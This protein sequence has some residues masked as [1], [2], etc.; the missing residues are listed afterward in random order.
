MGTRP[1]HG[2]LPNAPTDDWNALLFDGRVEVTLPGSER[3]TIYRRATTGV[4]TY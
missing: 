2:G 3:E 1:N 4:D